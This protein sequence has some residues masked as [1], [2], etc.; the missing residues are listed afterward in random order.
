MSEQPV[1]YREGLSLCR[2]WTRVEFLCENLPVGFKRE[3]CVVRSVGE[4]HALG[5]VKALRIPAV[6]AWFNPALAR[7]RRQ[8]PL[9]SL[10][11]CV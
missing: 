1:L 10:G 11:F 4:P 8:D 7:V 2:P 3:A 6:T 5:T 9:V